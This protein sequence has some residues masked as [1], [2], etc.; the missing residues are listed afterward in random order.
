MRQ[1]RPDGRAVT[2]TAAD[3]CEECEWCRLGFRMLCE[4][5]KSIGVGHEG[6]FAE[7]VVIPARHA[8]RLASEISMLKAVLCERMSIK[9]GDAVLVAGAGVKG[10]M[11]AQGAVANG[12]IVIMTGLERDAGAGK[13]MV[14]LSCVAVSCAVG[15][16]V[17]R[18]V[19][20]VGAGMLIYMIAVGWILALFNSRFK[21]R[22][23]GLR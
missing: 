8:F 1:F 20:Q 23:T 5:R 12:G 3:T 18:T 13:N 22:L 6:G 19:H 2:L 7:Y 9:P 15:L 10:Q 11:A 17:D 16:L 14:N 21:E 4:K